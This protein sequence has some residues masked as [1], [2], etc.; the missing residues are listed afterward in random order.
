MIMSQGCFRMLNK[1]LWVSGILLL[2]AYAWSS[3]SCAAIGSPGGGRRILLPTLFGYVQLE[4]DVALSESSER[5]LSKE[6]RF[7]W[8]LMSTTY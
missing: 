6:R 2:L 8:N 1:W 7:Y 3:T 4:P 5:L